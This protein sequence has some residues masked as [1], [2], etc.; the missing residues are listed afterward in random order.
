MSKK[1]T[2]KKKPKNLRP[3]LTFLDKSIYVFCM[4][5]SFMSLF[6]VF[7]FLMQVQESIA[8]SR[9]GTLAYRSGASTLFAWPLLFLPLS[10]FIF[11][12]CCME[13]K[14]PIFGDKSIQ[15][16]FPPYSA[17]CIPLFNRSKYSLYEKPSRKRF[18]KKA[19]LVWC[20]VFLVTLCLVPFGLCGRTSLFRDHRIEKINIFNQTVETY[21]PQEYPHLTIEAHRHRRHWRYSL[22]VEMEDGN[23]FSFSGVDFIADSEDVYLDTMLEIKALFD[24]EDIIVEGAENVDRIADD[25][26]LDAEQRKKLEALFSE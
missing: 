10:I 22:T 17:D 1:K 3:P 5:L 12:L 13:E 26:E 23:T 9:E 6:A 25:L 4:V 8:A 15:Y 2:K 24:P 19:I 16:G 11:L 18:L 20:S 21:T 7:L 14:K